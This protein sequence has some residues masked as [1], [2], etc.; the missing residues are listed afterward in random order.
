M[1]IHAIADTKTEEQLLSHCFSSPDELDNRKLKPELFTLPKHRQLFE[2]MRKLRQQGEPISADGV[3][4]IDATLEDVAKK[5]SL[6]RLG[7]L[8]TRTVVAKLC[9]MEKRRAMQEVAAQLSESAVSA[10][11]PDAVVSEQL[12]RLMARE[13][14]NPDTCRSI[15]DMQEVIDILEWKAAH[16]GE[17]RGLS[18]GYTSL[19]RY[20]DGLHSGLITLAARPTE[21]K[22]TLLLNVCMNVASIMRERGDDRQVYM[23]N[24][25]M[26]THE[27][28]LRA[29]SCLSGYPLDT[30]GLTNEQMR[31]LG[32]AIREIQK[33]RIVLEG[34]GHPYI[35]DVERT[36]RRLHRDKRIAMAAIDYAQLVRV[37]KSKGDK[38]SDLD[39][40]SKTLQA[41][42]MELDIPIIAAAQLKRSEKQWNKKEQKWFVP[43]PSIDDVKGCGSFEEDS[44]AVW[45]LHRDENDNTGLILGK[46]RHGP[47][48]KVIPLQYAAPIYR[49]TEKTTP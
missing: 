25:E 49:F 5:L 12:S 29:A 27:V 47:R 42:G 24:Y 1:T 16:P 21:G 44:Y 3:R 7:E 15:G 17:I 26:A 32:N 41:L 13:G 6:R 31:Q 48:F 10:D 40:V 18:T 33:M 35:D 23:G 38:V 30:G 11:D 2:A 19:D 20:T 22:S 39:K 14:G 36:I 28:Q 46:N 37:R 34:V 9:E 8:T 45:L 43:S 4:L